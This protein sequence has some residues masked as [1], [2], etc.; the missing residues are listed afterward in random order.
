MLCTSDFADNVMFSH[1][2]ANG[3]ESKTTCMFRRVRLVAAPG[4]T[5]AVSDC[6]LL[7]P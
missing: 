2:G 6:T 3:T 5:S 1:N 4:A 7:V